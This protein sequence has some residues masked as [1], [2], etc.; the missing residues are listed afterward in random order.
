MIKGNL[1]T[2]FMSKPKRIWHIG[3]YLQFVKSVFSAFYLI[4]NSCLNRALLGPKTI[5]ATL[6][7]RQK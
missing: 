6:L 4:L 5:S 7:L 1:P 3:S 2:Y